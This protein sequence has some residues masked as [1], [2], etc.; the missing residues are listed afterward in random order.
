[1]VDSGVWGAMWLPIF[2]IC[3]FRGI[4][5]LVFTRI[6]VLM[7]PKR[8]SMPL[9]KQADHFPWPL[10]T[11]APTSSSSFLCHISFWCCASCSIN[12]LAWFDNKKSDAKYVQ[13]LSVVTSLSHVHIVYVGHCS[14]QCITQVWHSLKQRIWF[15]FCLIKGSLKGAFGVLF[16]ITG[17]NMW[18]WGCHTLAA[19][20]K[21]W[22]IFSLQ[23]MMQ[24]K[25]GYCLPFHSSSTDWMGRLGRELPQ[26]GSLFEPSQQYYWDPSWVECGSVLSAS[27]A[28]NNSPY[29][30]FWVTGGHNIY[31]PVILS[32]MA[33]NVCLTLDKDV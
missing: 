33:K 3:T 29:A 25:V 2:I 28:G 9:C 27:I 26:R 12:K 30:M 14:T 24:S 7:Q 4:K 16:P 8:I 13:I 23:S 19:L 18:H 1:M 21:E 5:Y 10:W 17:T 6:L 32:T 11:S 31:P 22:G 15:F 20:I